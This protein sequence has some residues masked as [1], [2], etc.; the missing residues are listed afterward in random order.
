MILGGGLGGAVIRQGANV[1]VNAAF[2]HFSRKDE[3]EADYLG[4]QYLYAAGYDPTGAISI[5][6]KLE[7][8]ER[9][10]PGTVARIF[11]THPMDATRIEKTEQEIER[12]LPSKTSTSSTPR[13]TVRFASA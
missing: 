12:I 4:V 6:E 2:L 1:G 5:F 9:K 13:S 10:Q 7:S 3:S 11:S 8:L